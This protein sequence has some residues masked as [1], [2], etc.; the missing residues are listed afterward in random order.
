[1]VLSVGY[2]WAGSLRPF[3][4]HQSCAVRFLASRPGTSSTTP[5]WKGLT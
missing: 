2:V 5:W 4:V 3:I 1:M